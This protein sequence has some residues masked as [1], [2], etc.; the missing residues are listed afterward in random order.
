MFHC[1]PPLIAFTY[2]DQ[3]TSGFP[4]AIEVREGSGRGERTTMTTRL[5]PGLKFG[6]FGTIVKITAAVWLS[7]KQQN[8]NIQIWRENDTHP[9]LY[10]KKSSDIPLVSSDPPCYTPSRTVVFQCTLTEE[11][12][13]SV[14]PGDFLGLEIPPTNDDNLEIFFRSGG[15]TNYV[16]L[17]Q[18]NFTA[19]LS[20]AHFVTNDLPQITFL[21]V[22]GN[23]Q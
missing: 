12:R 1:D 14:Q 21:V 4:S 20:E 5:F 11:A 18:L 15:P 22:L 16:F 8:P 13:V 17:H 3:C 6:C 7:N 10:Y 2:L 19:N 23:Q 9:G